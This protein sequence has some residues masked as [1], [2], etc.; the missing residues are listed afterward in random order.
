MTN[1]IQDSLTYH[2][3]L[4]IKIGG[5]ERNH[6]SLVDNLLTWIIAL[7]FNFIIYD[8]KFLQPFKIIQTFDMSNGLNNNNN[9]NL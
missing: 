4:Y 9:T 7:L 8:F 2:T 6:N 3:T 5:F 1:A